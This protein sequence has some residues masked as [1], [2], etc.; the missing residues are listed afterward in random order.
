MS[1]VP[2]EKDVHDYDDHV[3]SS[4]APLMEHLIELRS[5]L[6]KSLLAIAVAF[7]SYYALMAMNREVQATVA[8]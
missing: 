1:A 3:E 7:A 6:I 8:N 4:R 2:P 5:R